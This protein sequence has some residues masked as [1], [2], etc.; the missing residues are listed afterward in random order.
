MLP[1]PSPFHVGID[2]CQIS[3]IRALIASRY[4]LRFL[5]RIFS[6][7]EQK[8]YAAR[9]AP[10]YS[11]ARAAA[12][13]AAAAKTRPLAENN[14]TVL[15]TKPPQTTAAEKSKDDVPLESAI[16]LVAGR[17]AAKE[18]AFKAHPLHRL[19][20]HD[21]HILHRAIIH[22]AETSRTSLSQNGGSSAPCAVIQAN[23]PFTTQAQEA[24][25]SISHDGDYATAVCIGFVAPA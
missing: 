5:N 19:G 4:G 20:F 12:A 13:T 18:A 21:V 22:H 23:P 16:R 25:I 7:E 14:E 11:L 3:R 17:F 15:V 10:A 9:L 6:A 8:A 1:F 24:R 2:I